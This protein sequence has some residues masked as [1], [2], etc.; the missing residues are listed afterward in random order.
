[1]I[2]N[3][4]VVT[5]ALNQQDLILMEKIKQQ[6]LDVIHQRISSSQV[7]LVRLE[8][9]ESWIR[10]YNYGLD[11]FNYNYGPVLEETALEELLRKK[12][13]LL[14][15]ADPYIRQLE[16]ML[17]NSECI[18]LLT[19]E[20]GVMLRVIEGGKE[21]LEQQ[22][23]RFRLVPGSIWTEETIG[24]CAHGISL[25]T[26]TPMQICGSEH[27]CE[28]YEQISCSSAPIFDSNGNLAGT[29]CIVSPSF[30]HQTSHSLGFGNL[31]GLG[32]FKM[33]FN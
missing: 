4:N 32:L 22:N 18:I 16:T 11:V 28:K 17:S 29:L 9:V 6:K 21:L 19:D 23:K 5:Q 30:H 20:Q 33:N 15:A 8:V 12:D 2:A 31:H 14:N 7:D 1:M 13:L 25:I 24:T 27:Y 3:R 26:K 10:S